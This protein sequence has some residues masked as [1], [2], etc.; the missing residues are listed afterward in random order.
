[1]IFSRPFSF[2]YVDVV[3]DVDLFQV[4]W[5]MGMG[6]TGWPPLLVLIVY[7]KSES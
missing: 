4:K 7:M 3:V 5:R 6:M 2:G 1:M